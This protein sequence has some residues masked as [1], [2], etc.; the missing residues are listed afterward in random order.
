MPRDLSIA[1]YLKKE[2][3]DDK[4]NKFKALKAR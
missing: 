2:N 4:K 3:K 1:K